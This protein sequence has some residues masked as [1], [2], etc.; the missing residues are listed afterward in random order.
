MKQER[1]KLISGKTYE[2]RCGCGELYIICNDVAGELFEV[3]VR[4]GKNG[5]CGSSM[6]NGIAVLVSGRL[7]SGSDALTVVKE[8][9][10]IVCHRASDLEPSC[11]D[12]LAC[13]IESHEQSRG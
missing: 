12:S 8:L 10:G 5:S 6:M 7:R 11:L 2:A 1:P 3:F 13:T 9:K 4:L